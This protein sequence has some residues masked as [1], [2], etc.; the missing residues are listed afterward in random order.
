MILP[1][2]KV[3]ENKFYVIDYLLNKEYFEELKKDK[4]AVRKFTDYFIL[5][6]E[7]T[8]AISKLIR[9]GKYANFIKLGY[10]ENKLELAKESAKNA[11]YSLI[12]LPFS[13]LTPLGKDLVKKVKNR[14]AKKEIEKAI[15]E[16]IQENVKNIIESKL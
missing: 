9:S 10:S 2:E 7:N 12:P 5:N 16:L 15:N 6:S 8:K 13:L 1:I 4:D 14:S 3:L 11:V